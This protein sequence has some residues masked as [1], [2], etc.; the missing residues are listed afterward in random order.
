MEKTFEQY[1]MENGLE[2]LLWQW[3]NEKN[4]PLRP[5]QVRYGTQKKAWWKCERGHRWQAVVYA[6]VTGNG[7]PYCAQKRALAGYNDLAT[8]FPEI[9]AQWDAEKNDTLTPQDVLAYSNKKVWW[10]C[11]QGHSYVAEISKRTRQHSG[12]PYCA[13]KLVLPS[14]NDLA[15]KRP[16][17]A[18]QWHPSMNA[19]LM[20][21]QVTCGSKRS[22]WWQCG[23][24]HAW[25]AVIYSRTAKRAAGCPVCAKEMA[26]RSYRQPARRQQSRTAAAQE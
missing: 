21:K 9:A 4:L 22:V 6:R 17:V 24:G 13:N 10:R 25:K 16:D 1:C 12:C 11:G 26:G 18:K 2:A 8:K 3:D 19:G 14:F 7:C 20:P 5:D 23:Y 15:S